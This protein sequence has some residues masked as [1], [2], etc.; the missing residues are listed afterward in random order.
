M[1][2][3]ITTLFTELGAIGGLMNSWNTYSGTTF[4]GKI[5]SLVGDY[6]ATPSLVN[7]I[8]TNL[9]SFQAGGSA[10][11]SQ[12]QA[13]FQSTIVY[14]IDAEAAMTS[15]SLTAAIQQLISEFVA[16]AYYVAPATVSAT[17][18]AGG[19]NSGNAAVAVGL[20]TQ[21]GKQLDLIYA[22]T[23]LGT[24]TGD[25]QSGSATLGQE[26]I[27]FA[28]QYVAPSPLSYLYPAG[29][30][31]NQTLTAVNA[32]S[33]KGSGNTNYLY[34][35][36]FEATWTGSVPNGWHVTAG[37]G[38]ITKS[39]AQHY[40]GV[41][42]LAIAGD[43]STLTGIESQ[44]L[45][46]FPGDS[47]PTGISPSTQYCFCLWLKCDVV[48]AAGVI[49]VA[50]VNASGTI[51]QDVAG[52]NA[53]VTFNLTGATTS[54]AAFNGFLRTPRV[55]PSATYLRIRLSTAM[56]VGSNLFIDRVSFTQPTPLY[57]QGPY[58]AVFSGSSP[59]IIGDTE[60]IAVANN[61]AN[62][63]QILLDRML[64]LKSLGLLFPTSGTTAINPALIA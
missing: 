53:A 29:S 50:L 3:N 9:A 20:K 57:P 21:T 32:S 16:G 38:Q 42:S 25:A 12:L 8:Y 52:N 58:I 31:C 61:Y 51:L 43:G 13:L 41:N 1:A 6:S 62:A 28:G 24:V 34:N 36:D 49:E 59:L 10:I 37:A 54:F 30:G 33:Y 56:S 23:V 5:N 17:V 47:T 60:S 22:E 46:D 19:S 14:E 64:G 4:P 48:P 18:T 40:D 45:A 7:G 55:L 26:T 27:T 11:L 39:T 35:G 63:W 2:V 15:T 44:F